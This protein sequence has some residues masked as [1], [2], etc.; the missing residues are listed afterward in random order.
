M[1]L[2]SLTYVCQHLLCWIFQFCPSS[3][4]IVWLNGRFWGEIRNC[5]WISF[6]ALNTLTSWVIYDWEMSEH[7]IFSWRRYNSFPETTVL[8]YALATM[9]FCVGMAFCEENSI[10]AWSASCNG[11]DVS[12]C[13]WLSVFFVIFYN[14][15]LQ[16]IWSPCGGV[17]LPN[18]YRYK[19]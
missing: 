2:V 5:V 10:F 6:K 18:R 15:K 14:F 3:Y 19:R 1:G 8:L 16:S 9:L 4:L 12:Y 11:F 17:V 13:Y 7:V